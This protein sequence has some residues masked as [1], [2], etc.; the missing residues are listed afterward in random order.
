[1]KPTVA[2]PPATAH[3]GLVVAMVAFCPFSLFLGANPS[4]IDTII[5]ADIHK[6]RTC[7]TSTQTLNSASKP[8]LDHCLLLLVNE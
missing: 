1:M 8:L 3:V 7:H 4:A 2:P 6:G 5:P